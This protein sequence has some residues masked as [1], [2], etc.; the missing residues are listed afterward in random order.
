[1]ASSGQF[2]DSAQITSIICP[3]LIVWGTQDEIIPVAHAEKFHRDI[4]NSRTIIYNPC[5]HCPMIEVPEKLVPDLRKFF[6]E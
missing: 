6:S 3:T 5:G 4:R 2:P 1:M